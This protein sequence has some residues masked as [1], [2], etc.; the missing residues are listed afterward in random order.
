MLCPTTL[1]AGD[2]LSV[3]KEAKKE[4]NIFRRFRR[5]TATMEDQQRD[6][7]STAK[8]FHQARLTRGPDGLALAQFAKPF[9]WRRLY[10]VSNL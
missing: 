10:R 9:F 2:C 6:V 1:S 4:N 7:A 3:R 5:S 8:Q